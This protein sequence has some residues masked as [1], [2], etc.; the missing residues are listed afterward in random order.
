MLIVKVVSGSFEIVD[1]KVERY[2]KKERSFTK[3]E[4]KFIRRRGGNRTSS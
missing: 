2:G 3:V 1:L 4:K